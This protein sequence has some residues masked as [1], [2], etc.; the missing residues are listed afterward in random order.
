MLSRMTGF[1]PL[2][3][4]NNIRVCV[5]VRTRARVCVCVCVCVL[6]PFIHQKHLDCVHALAIVSNAAVDMGCRYVFDIVISFPSGTFSGVEG[7]Q[8]MVVLFLIF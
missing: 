4:L 1:P 5:Y 3:C 6:D 2:L 8:H 7:L